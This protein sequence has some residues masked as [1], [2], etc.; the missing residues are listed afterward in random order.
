MTVVFKFFPSLN[1]IRSITNG[2]PSVARLFLPVNYVVNQF[3]SLRVPPEFGMVQANGKTARIMAVN[4]GANTV[5]LDLDTTG[6]DPY[7]LPIAY[8]QLPLTIPAG[9]FASTLAASVLDNQLRP[10]YVPV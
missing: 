3:I 1:A 4:T 2:Y 6:F 8:T 10:G 7:V 5:T 9:E